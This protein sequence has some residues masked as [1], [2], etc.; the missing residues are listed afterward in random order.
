MIQLLQ[1][2]FPYN[3]WQC[4]D[5]ETGDRLRV[6]PERGGLITEWKCN[7]KEILYFDL[8]R[9]ETKGKS[10][11]GGIPILFPICGNLPDDEFSLPQG[12]F[13][14]KQHG[15]A[16]ELPWKI[17]SLEDQK[18]LSLTLFDNDKTRKS[19]PFLFSLE[20]QARIYKNTLEIKT[21]VH[22]RGKEKMPFTFG[23]HPYFKFCDFQNVS[24]EGLSET[25]MN[26]L[27][28]SLSSTQKQLEQLSEGVDFLAS[29]KGYVSAMDLKTGKSVRM[30]NKFP[31]DLAVIWTDPPREMVCLEPWTSPR[32]SLKSG[33]RR[34]FVEPLATQELICRFVSN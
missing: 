15:F 18:G 4:I 25:C 33:E 2:T 23:L 6:V 26:H 32:S 12:T 11:R 16:R 20:V 31:M 19:Y 29:T 17:K 10:V 3:H 22:N 5:S 7:G 34:L 30:L 21:F 1:K 13:R 9:F 14:I 27:D 28:M 24:F 8:D